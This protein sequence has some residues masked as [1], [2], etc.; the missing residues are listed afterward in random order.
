MNKITTRGFYLAVDPQV[1]NQV[2]SAILVTGM[3]RTGSTLLGNLLHSCQGVEYLFEPPALFGLF[4][5][6][7][8]IPD[9][10]WMWLYGMYLF[11]DFLLDAVAGR[12]L[13][14]NPH[15]AS[16]FG[17][18]K[19]SGDLAQRLGRTW[20]TE[21]LFQ[22]ASERR[23]CYKMPDI[24]PWV[25]KLMELFPG[26]KVVLT[27]RSSDYIVRSLLRKRWFGDAGKAARWYGWEGRFP[28]WLPLDLRSKWRSTDECGRC[29]LYVEFMEAQASKLEGVAVV[30]YED[31]TRSPRSVF[32]SLTKQLDLAWGPRSE[33]LLASVKE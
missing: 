32:A 15:D 24:V 9:R 5:L 11:G 20:P 12:R 10:D 31:L 19:S 13:N 3:A 1:S 21:E 29:W 8:T 2:G 25:P 6:L 18:A 26:T 22:L 27:V 4:P 23:I 30:K 17:A 28:I 16:Y 14:L 33:Q 7:D